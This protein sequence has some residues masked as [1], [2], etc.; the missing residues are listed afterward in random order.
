MCSLALYGQARNC[1]AKCKHLCT[2]RPNQFIE[3]QRSSFELMEKN[4]LAPKP[5]PVPVNLES[6][7][8]SH[9]QKSN[10]T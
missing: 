6:I 5:L 9:A 3:Q 8:R 7:N 4:I 1:A 2:A 10:H